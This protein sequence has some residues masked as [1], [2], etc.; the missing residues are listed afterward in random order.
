LI[1]AAKKDDYGTVTE[2]LLAAGADMSVRSHLGNSPL[3]EAMTYGR[4]GSV[5]A[6]IHHGAN[7]NDLGH[8]SANSRKDT[9][10]E[11]AILKA[12][13]SLIAAEAPIWPSY[14]DTSHH[15]MDLILESKVNVDQSDDDGQTAL[16]YA[17]RDDDYWTVKRLLEAGADSNRMD[18]GGETPGS[19]AKRSNNPEV[20]A[21]I[22]GN[23]AGK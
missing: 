9:I 10:L 8:G 17:V 16:M 11:E 15:V 22:S 21:A 13:P 23:H 5:T 4:F 19:L 2:S 20:L 18:K 6:L 12:D 3:Y 14:G 1:I 7:V